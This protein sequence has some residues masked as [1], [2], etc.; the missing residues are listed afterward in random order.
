[1]KDIQNKAEEEIEE[2]FI[3]LELVKIKMYAEV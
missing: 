1:M 2:S 3:K